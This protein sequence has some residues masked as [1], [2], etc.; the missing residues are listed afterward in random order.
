MR[1][2]LATRKS[3]PCWLLV[4]ILW[5]AAAARA[6][7]FPPDPVEEL[8][9]ALRAPLREPAAREKLLTKRVDALRTLGEIRRALQLQEWNLDEGID[10]K[11]QAIDRPLREKLAARFEQGVREA[12]KGSP[13]QQKA[14]AQMLAELGLTVRGIQARTNL[15]RA[16]TQELVNAIQQGEPSVRQAAAR[17]LGQIY[18]DPQVAVPALAGL[19]RSGN[20]ADRVA[21]LDGLLALLRTVTQNQTKSGNTLQPD[22]MPADVVGVGRLI[23]PVATGAIGDPDVRVRRLAAEIV[24]ESAESLERLTPDIRAQEPFVGLEDPRKKAEEDFGNLLPLMNGL[25]DQAPQLARGMRDGDALVRRRLHRAAEEMGVARIRLLARAGSIAELEG[26]VEPPEPGK[27]LPP[28]KLPEDPLLDALL[29]LEPALTEGVSDPDLQ[30]RLSAIDALETLVTYARPA[31]PALTRALDDPNRFVRWAAARVL[32][33]I[34][35]V[36]R[37][38]SVP[39]LTRMLNDSDLDLRRAAAVALGRYGPAGKAAVPTL[40]EVLGAPDAEMR[41]A[42]IH[43]LVGIGTDSAPA[44]PW[45]ARLL[46]DLDARVRQAAAEALGKFGPAAREAVPALRAALNDE[47][48]EVRR[49]VSD[50]LLS[51]LPPK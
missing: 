10:E 51:I 19:L 46:S 24:L 35:P 48:P 9:L 28:V 12:F 31:A 30:A 39:G 2:I 5:P 34:G 20:P 25:K 17:A 44:I 40:I 1:Q 21:A 36:D 50:A 32:G 23:V 37:V 42:A 22:I 7:R 4:A 15:S 33:R 29:V 13:I 47:N 49:T 41:V 27:L 14:A 6:D 16:F 38:D 43:S 26:K 3:L 8:R 45:F 18:P 11:L